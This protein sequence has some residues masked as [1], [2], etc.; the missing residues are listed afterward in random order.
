MSHSIVAIP[1]HETQIIAIEE[2]GTKWVSIRHACDSIGI[3]VENQRRKLKAKPWAVAVMKTA[4]AGDGKSYE[5]TMIDRKTFTM[6]LATIE[7]SRVKDERARLMIE[8]FQDE[9]ADA[10]DAYFNDGGAVNPRVN[11]AQAQSLSGMALAQA[12]LNL[13][14]QATSIADLDPV[15]VTTMT[16]L[17]LEKGLNNRPDIPVEVRPLYTEDYLKSQ[18]VSGK[19]LKSMR[20]VF[21]RAVAAEYAKRYGVKPMKAFGEVGS[22][23]RQIN[24]YTEQDRKLFDDVFA[25]KFATQG[26]LA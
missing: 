7:T 24:S 9:A 13:I 20:S 17:A 5:M 10:L 12:Q 19:A 22:R 4:T 16:T 18:G 8:Q 3:D 14:Q 26:V 2:D 6:W 11:V 23:A 25:E 21:G 15:Y 1:F